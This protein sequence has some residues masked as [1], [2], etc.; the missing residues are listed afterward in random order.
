[1]KP[2]PKTK[3]DKRNKTLLKKNSLQGHVGKL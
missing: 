1:M 2:G 3:N